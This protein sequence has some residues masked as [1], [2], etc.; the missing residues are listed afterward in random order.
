MSSSARHPPGAGLRIRIAPDPV[1]L[2]DWPLRQRPAS[3]LAVLALAG[4]ASWIVGWA[5]MHWEAGAIAAAALVITLWRT[6]LPTRFELSSSGIAQVFAGRWKRRI[7]WSAIG[8]YDVRS[9][10]VLLVPDPVITP[11]SSL[12]GLYLH[13]GDQRDAV[14]ANLEYYVHGWRAGS[15]T[16]THRTE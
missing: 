11:L 6:W 12:R 15:R 16:S 13:W 8:A 7:P 9:D 4:G 14:L 1:S 3:S 2:V 5:S 10:G